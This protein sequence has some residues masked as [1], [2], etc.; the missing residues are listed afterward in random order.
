MI[1]AIG[2]AITFFLSLI[3][4]T[5]KEKS[6][7]DK[8]L[9]IWLCFIG[10][11]L[12]LFYL[13]VSGNYT[14]TP[15]LLGLELPMPLL[16]GPFLFVYTTSLSTPKRMSGKDVLHATPF[17]VGLLAMIPFFTLSPEEK[18]NVYL[19]EG[20][21]YS[22]LVG[23]FLISIILSGLAYSIL[24]LWFLRR[25]QK[26][27]LNEYS[28]TEKINLRWLYFLIVGL[29]AIWIIVIV[30]DDHYVFSAVVTYVLFIGYFG[31]KQVGIFTNQSSANPSVVL[32][33]EKNEAE[34][35]PEKDKYKKSGLT[36][37]QLESIHKR[38][39]QVMRDE[40]L[41]LIPE[42]TL[43]EVAKNLN[44]HPNALSQ[45]VNQLEQKNFFDYING[46]RI[47]EFKKRIASS[48]HQQFTLL[49]IAHD[50]GF[51]SKTSFNRNFKKLTG[52][53]PT[54]YLEQADIR[55]N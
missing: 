51:N 9:A 32:E 39:T 23:V 33:L 10:V 49:S 6:N 30:A 45:V 15:N 4:L 8:V 41:Y 3:L 24:S 35:Q 40:K 13:I 43:S 17:L 55:L 52:I 21:G 36:E 12:I 18:T 54:E 20:K 16:H 53:S 47:E 44:T 29:S 50:C 11:H 34:S 22:T 27:I 1:Y 26:G 7:A 5:K 37:N 46:L 38:L 19:Q 25:Y 14:R 2:I 42:L 28:F 48:E 31:I